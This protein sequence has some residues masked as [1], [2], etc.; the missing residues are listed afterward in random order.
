MANVYLKCID[1]KKHEVE[2]LGKCL[3]DEDDMSYTTACKYRCNAC[4][5]QMSINAYCIKE[6]N[7]ILKE[8]FDIFS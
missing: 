2:Y 7:D 5:K 1:C 3:E 6:H 8:V 4:G